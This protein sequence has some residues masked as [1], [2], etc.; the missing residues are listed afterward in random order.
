MPKVFLWLRYL[1]KHGIEALFPFVMDY[2]I[3]RLSYAHLKVNLRI[4]AAEEAYGTV[5]VEVRKYSKR[6]GVEVV[7]VY[8]R[9]WNA[10]LN[11]RRRS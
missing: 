11:D 8:V 6:K 4:E 1:D 9:M 5:S 3:P 10:A 7:Q 2:R